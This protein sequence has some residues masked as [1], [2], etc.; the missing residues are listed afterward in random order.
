MHTVS[1]SPFLIAKYEVTQ[2]QYEA[3]MA[4]HATLDDTPSGF[5]A[6]DL[7][8]EQVS[9]NDLHDGDGFLQRTGFVLPTEAQC[10]Y[11]AGTTRTAFFL[12]LVLSG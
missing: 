1:L 3:V 5:I 9:W 11:F 4:G 10:T 8:V 2:S 7:P 6:S 12:S